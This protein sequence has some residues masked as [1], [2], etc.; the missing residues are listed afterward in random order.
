MNVKIIFRILGLLLVIEGISMLL[1]LV[2]A[3]I[4][5]GDD[6]TAFTLS[7]LICIIP[8][9]II[10]LLTGNA[11]KNI[12]KR[13]GFLTVTLVW[14]IFSLFG[15]LPYVLSGSIPNF[16]NAFFETMSGFS[17]TGATVL[18]GIE[19]LPHGILFWRS[20]TQWLGGMGIIALSLSLLPLFG[21]GGMQLFAA[22]FPGPVPDKVSP[23]V[24]QTARLFWIIYLSFTLIETVLLALGGMSLFDSIC[25]AFTTMGS[26]GFSTKQASIAHWDSPFI[27]YVIILFMMIAGTNFTLIYYSIK[28]RISK[29]YSDEE[30]QYYIIFI[31]VFT[32]LIFAGLLITTPAGAEESFRNS[33]FQV[34]SV[35][36]T[37]GFATVD[38]MQWTPV[39]IMLIFG[40]FFF[41]G[42]AG[43]TSGGV[44]IMRV[45][46]LLKN[47]Y[48]ELKRLMHPN[49][50]IPVRFNNR[51]VDAKIMLNVLAF[52]AFYVL[53]FFASATVFMIF[54][55][56]FETSAG[57]VASCLGN[58][59][60]GLGSVGPSETFLHIHPAGKWFLSFLMLLGRLE[61]FTVLA[62]FTPAFWKR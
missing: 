24:A 5:N 22:E 20:L 37:T 55:P 16:T 42:S 35:I 14:M 31:V 39:L 49:A 34:V 38:Y 3:L 9:I 26:G 54:E 51:S 62:L 18:E 53:V 60:P 11:G 30:F 50:V 13:E 41:G 43:S 25:H 4:H 23:K 47:S 61:L 29:L 40:L 1:A 12:S 6:A 28:G 33:L 48:Y 59:G 7:S 58:V 27:H 46:L 21:I 56:D 8:G 10:V 45:V 15:S 36:S 32:V 57:A 17:T 2:I 19:S 44:K 52:F